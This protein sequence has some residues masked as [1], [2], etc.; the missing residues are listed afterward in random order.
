[1]IMDRHMDLTA[2]DFLLDRSVEMI[3]L[4]FAALSSMIWC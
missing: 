3:Q 4:M 2:N 1:M